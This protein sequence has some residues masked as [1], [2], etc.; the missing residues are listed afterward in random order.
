MNRM[1]ELDAAYDKYS[2]LL[3]RVGRK[4]P[5]GERRTDIGFPHVAFSQDGK[6][7]IISTD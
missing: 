7:S 4:F 5:Y 2:R 3:G 1:A 6:V